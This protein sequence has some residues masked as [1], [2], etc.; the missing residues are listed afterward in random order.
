MD[1]PNSRQS[2]VISL[3]SSTPVQINNVGPTFL[4]TSL[5]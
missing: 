2:A 5:Q 3:A 4:S 1:L